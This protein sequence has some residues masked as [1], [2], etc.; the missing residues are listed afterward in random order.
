LAFALWC[1][2]DRNSS[3]RGQSVRQVTG[4]AL[5][6]GSVADARDMRPVH[7]AGIQAI[8]D[9][10]GNEPLL[11]VAR[12]MV[13]YRFPLVDGP[14]NQAWQLTLSQLCCG[15]NCQHPSFAARE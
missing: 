9:L 3:K 12:D 6:L 8:V 13:Y 1:A 5:W 2:F 7:A 4:F 15:S 11:P 14:E 10:A